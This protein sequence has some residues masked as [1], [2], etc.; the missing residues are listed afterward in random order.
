[1]KCQYAD[2]FSFFHI[3]SWPSSK[4]D[5]LYLREDT[6]NKTSKRFFEQHEIFPARLEIS[7]ELRSQVREE[8]GTL[9]RKIV[10]VVLT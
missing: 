6:A 9:L 4:F 3:N 8:C 5:T 10:R 2:F 7:S 1:M